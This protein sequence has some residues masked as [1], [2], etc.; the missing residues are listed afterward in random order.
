MR[1]RFF[2]GGWTILIA[3][4]LFTACS[5][6]TKSAIFRDYLN[7]ITQDKE[8]AAI[9][10]GLEDSIRSWIDRGLDPV[11]FFHH[12]DW[13]VDSVVFFDKKKERAVLLVL[14]RTNSISHPLD[15]VKTIG[16]EKINGKWEYYYASY[17]VI[18]CQRSSNNNSAYSFSDL[19][20]IGRDELINDGFVECNLGCHINYDYIDSDI[21][22]AQWMRD[23]HK[24][25]LTNSLPKDPIAKPGE[26][27]F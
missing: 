27:M 10:D 16:A 24:K 9:K 11:Q 22:F 5:N 6:G 15:Y 8:Y 7:S 20:R 1:R 25:F 18:E 17:A 3:F 12:A 19:A 14:V 23:M 2:I 4:L 13:K 21:W 26:R